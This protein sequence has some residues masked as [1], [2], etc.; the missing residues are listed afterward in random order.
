VLR[1]LDHRWAIVI[2][3]ALTLV[4]WQLPYGRLI[5][6]PLSILATYAH[7]MGHGFTALLMGASFEKLELFADGSGRAFWSGEVG[8]IGRALIAAGGLVGPSI[9]G[10]TGLALT[11]RP[12]LARHLL[13]ALGCLMLLSI[14]LVVRSLFGFVFVTMFALLFIAFAR[15]AGGR[16]APLVLQLVGVNLC[17]AIFQDVRYMFS[18]GGVIAGVKHLSDTAVIADALL[19][20]YWFWGALTAVFSFAVLALGIVLAFRFQPKEK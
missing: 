5:L 6:Y 19:L 20:P 18:E 12:R 10:A 14:V 2:I 7:E 1:R 11:S 4:I 13:F 9:A 16:H 3:A 15:A 8:R 17:L